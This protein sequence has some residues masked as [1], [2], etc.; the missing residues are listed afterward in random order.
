MRAE[1]VLYAIAL[2][3]RIHSGML[4]NKQLLKE[5]GKKKEEKEGK[6]KEGERSIDKSQVSVNPQNTKAQ[7]SF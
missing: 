3:A 4:L 2:T 7:S 5:K 6:E 1:A